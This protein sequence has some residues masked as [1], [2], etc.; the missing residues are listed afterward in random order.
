MSNSLWRG[1]STRRC[2]R[3]LKID[4]AGLSKT[5]RL[6]A[7]ASYAVKGLSMLVGLAAVPAYM[8]YFESSAVL[9]TWYTI[10]T[11][12]QWVLMFDLGIG[13]GLRNELVAAL[14]DK[15]GKAVSAYVSSSYRLMGVVCILLAIVVT[16]LGAFVPWNAAL[17]IDRSLISA[18]VLSACMTVV[19]VG[20]VVQLFLQLVNGILYALQL[21]SVVNALG[22]ISNTLILAFVLTA[23]STGDEANLLML[24]FA[25]V[26]SM[27]LPPMVA[28]VI[29]FR[30]KLLGVRVCWRS[31]EWSYARRTLSTGLVILVL[32]VAWM[33]VASTHSLLISL[34]RNPAE[35]VDYQVYYK[36]YYTFGSVAAIALVPIWSAVTA[37]AAQG[38][39]EWIV[40]IYR[41]C[42]FLALAVGAACLAIAPFLQTGFD[43]WLG[44]DSISV[45]PWYVLPMSLFSVVF[46]LQNVNASIGNGISY[47]KVQLVLMGL[48][49]VL[50]VPLSY[51]LCSITGSW[52]GVIIATIAAIMPFQ[53]VEPIACIRHLRKLEHDNVGKTGKDRL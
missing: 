6:N 14:V 32:Q 13:N 16:L 2:S 38:Q 25:N 31:F 17:N 36:V 9:G 51:A 30:R 23:P 21:S 40:S 18:R 4:S 48:A 1:V 50:M 5:I 10:Q 33:V 22:L 52:I 37:A 53:I 41:K 39:Y 12:L 27:L 15:D 11:A 49:A 34:F 35:V 43:L 7:L 42:L 45:N 28:T 46:V 29:V 26:M 47:F 19:G 8:R 3:E 44:S 24:G 20:V